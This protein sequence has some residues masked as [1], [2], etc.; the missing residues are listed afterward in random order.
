MH[1]KTMD[2]MEINH[3]QCTRRL[4]AGV[5]VDSQYMGNHCYFG[6]LTHPALEYDVAVGIDVDDVQRF[7]KFNKLIVSKEGDVQ[8]RFGVLMP[9]EDKAKVQGYTA[10]AFVDGKMREFFIYESQFDEIIYK[11]HAIN[12]THEA[13]LF[14]NLVNL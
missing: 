4:R 10:K 7:L 1:A 14:E 3:K 2:T 8:Y 12:V 9:T 5:F 13:L 6:Y 11:G